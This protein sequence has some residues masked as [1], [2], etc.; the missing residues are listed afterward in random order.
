[1]Q[2]VGNGVRRAESS[3]RPTL[4]AGWRTIRRR[5]SGRT[6]DALVR[7]YQHAYDLDVIVDVRQMSYRLELC[8]V[9]RTKQ[10]TANGEFRSLSCTIVRWVLQCRTGRR[11][12]RPSASY[13]S[14]AQQSSRVRYNFLLS[15]AYRHMPI[16]HLYRAKVYA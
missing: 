14:V 2:D 11:H 3:Y 15:C 16:V 8:T 5:T 4:I 9:Y 10:C 13:W 12:R 1:M 6:Y 7:H